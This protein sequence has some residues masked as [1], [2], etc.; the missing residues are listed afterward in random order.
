MAALAKVHHLTTNNK[1]DEDLTFVTKRHG[2]EE[3]KMMLERRDRSTLLKRETI[4]KHN[5]LTYTIEAK[6]NHEMD[7]TSFQIVLSI[8]PKSKPKG[9]AN[10]KATPKKRKYTDIQQNDE[11]KN[12]PPKKRIKLNTDTTTASA[13]TIEEIE[14]EFEWSKINFSEW[15]FDAMAFEKSV[16][17]GIVVLGWQ[18]IKMNGWDAEFNIAPRTLIGFLYEIQNGYHQANMYHNRYHA[19]DVMYNVYWY[20]TNC[21]SIGKYLSAFDRFICVMAA[22]CH[23]VDHNGFNNGYHQRTKSPLAIRFNDTSILENHHIAYSLRLIASDTHLD[24]MKDLKDSGLSEKARKYLIRLILGTDM[25]CH[26]THKDTIHSLNAILMD[27]KTVVMCE[28]NK[29]DLLRVI[30]H[31]ADIANAAKTR[32]LCVEWAK[33]CVEEFRTQGDHEVRCFGKLPPNN[34]LLFD[35]KH[36]LE[37]SQEG[38]IKFVMLPYFKRLNKLLQNEIDHQIENLNSNLKYWT[39]YEACKDDSKDDA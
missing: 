5:N 35:R 39:E 3:A 36:P 37:T 21:S 1:L 15:N 22:A 23:D 34:T 33:R 26:N 30:L 2:S 28:D 4:Q 7:T 32:S 20:L 8:I 19:I 17:N 24:W 31:A 14:K 27:V 6:P 18:L 9:K 11:D 13:P 29:I 38:W 12:E 16:K 25:N 10:L